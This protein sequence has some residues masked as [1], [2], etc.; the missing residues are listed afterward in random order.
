MSVFDRLKLWPMKPQYDSE[1]LEKASK[2]LADIERKLATLG[3]GQIQALEERIAEQLP[4]IVAY[5]IDNGYLVQVVPLR[6]PSKLGISNMGS[7]HYCAD[8]AAIADYIVTQGARSKLNIPEQMDMFKTLHVPTP[9]MV[10]TTTSS[11]KPY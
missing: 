4:A 8:H 5:K 11:T 3:Q 2:R 7:F 1:S 10:V 6:D 9:N